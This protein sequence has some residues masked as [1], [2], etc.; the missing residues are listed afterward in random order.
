MDSLEDIA[1]HGISF[2]TARFIVSPRP[3]TLAELATLATPAVTAH[4]PDR[5]QVDAAGP[6][7]LAAWGADLGRMGPVSTIRTG[8]AFLG[9]LMLGVNPPEVRLGYLLT[10]SQWGKGY[11]TELVKGLVATLRAHAPL[12]LIA[13]V[14]PRNEA[15]YSV[16]LKAGFVQSQPA[17]DGTLMYRAAL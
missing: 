11:A 1:T 10:Q 9:A 2:Q 4:L 15:S 3:A 8:D 16:L 5:L 17:E 12:T 14:A 6:E 13:G 7:D